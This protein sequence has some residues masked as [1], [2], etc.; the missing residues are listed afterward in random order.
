MLVHDQRHWS[1][2]PGRRRR[3]VA[4]DLRRRDGPRRDHRRRSA[5]GGTDLDRNRVVS[6]VLGAD[7]KLALGQDGKVESALKVLMSGLRG[8]ANHDGGALAVGPDGKLYV[9]VGDS[10][11]NTGAPPEPPR[12]T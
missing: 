6:T 9:G 8:P 4:R 7:G 11:C 2:E 5:S 12:T 1:G 10:G 3:R